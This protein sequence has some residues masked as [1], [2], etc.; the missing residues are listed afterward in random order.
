M[1]PTWHPDHLTAYSPP[2]FIII[3]IN[4]LHRV[5]WCRWGNHYIPISLVP[6]CY[7]FNPLQVVVLKKST[8]AQRGKCK[9]M[10]EQAERTVREWLRN[11]FS[12]RLLDSSF[13]YTKFTNVREVEVGIIR[14][15]QIFKC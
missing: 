9:E 12:N 4:I 5:V 2:L 7:L 15:T 8:E 3:I 1:K 11:T 14:F 13:S 6:G 10:F